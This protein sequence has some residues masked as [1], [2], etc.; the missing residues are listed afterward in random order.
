V[1]ADERHV[2]IWVEVAQQATMG[3]LAFID[4][5]VPGFELPDP[6]LPD[7]VDGHGWSRHSSL[8]ASVSIGGWAAGRITANGVKTN[9][10]HPT[11]RQLKA[12]ESHR[13]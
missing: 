5:G 6:T 2:F 7:G 13:Q 10:I 12:S 9:L 8:P 3:A 11:E 4:L 1:E